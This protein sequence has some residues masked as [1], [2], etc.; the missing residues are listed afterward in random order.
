MAE[1]F[2][3]VD[4]YIAAQAATAQSA[5]RRVRAAIR[6][7]LPQAQETIAYNMPAYKLGSASVLQFAAAKDHYALYLATKPIVEAFGDDLRNCKV[8]KG[9]IRFSYGDPVPESLIQRIARFRAER[10][11][12]L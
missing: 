4:E 9:T 7:A 11:A 1:T 10:E 12:P 6:E 8:D 5:L 2:S 3:S